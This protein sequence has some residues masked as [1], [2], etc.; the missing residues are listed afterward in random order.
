MA[1][2]KVDEKIYAQYSEYTAFPVHFERLK[3]IYNVV[4]NYRNP[5][6]TVK[7]LDVGC[8]TGNVTIPLGTIPNSQIDGIDVHQGNIDISLQR[9]TFK[10]VSFKFQYLQDCDISQYDFIVLTEVL[11]HI[12]NYKE[13]LSYIAKNGKPT[14]QFLLTIPNG[15][16]PFEISQQ[17]LYAM[18]R[19]GM[20]DFIWKVKK[21][22]GKKEPYS[23]NY[24]TPHVNF[25][26]VKQLRNDLKSFNMKMAEIVN[27]HVVSPILETYLPFIP[28]KNIADIDNAIAQ[29]LPAALASGWYFR[30]VMDKK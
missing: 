11:E 1:F 19:M 16:G 10:N 25:F 17:P 27:A 9:N 6:E 22:L 24:D 5:N 20:N 2:T 14:V 4:Y 18:R 21:T 28:L 26:T 23:Q 13:I 30:I 8:G 15:R 3:W 7:V 29:K 12:P